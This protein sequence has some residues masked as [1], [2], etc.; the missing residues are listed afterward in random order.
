M[1]VTNI[2]FMH[3][4]ILVDVNKIPVSTTVGDSALGAAQHADC[5]MTALNEA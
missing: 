2:R 5:P 3:N 4:Y 1:P